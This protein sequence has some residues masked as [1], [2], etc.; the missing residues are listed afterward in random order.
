MTFSSYRHDLTVRTVLTSS[1]R[2]KLSLAVWW[3]WWRKLMMMRRLGL[4]RREGKVKMLMPFGM[5]H[6]GWQGF[7]DSISW[8][9]RLFLRCSSRSRLLSS[10]MLLPV[11]ASSLL[12]TR[13]SWSDDSEVRT[14]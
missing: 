11:I 12:P 14:T 3:R 6:D 5:S 8:L 7:H 10:L 9:V 1:S 2:K 4:N 13:L